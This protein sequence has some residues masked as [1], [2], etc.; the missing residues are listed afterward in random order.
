MFYE[1]EAPKPKAGQKEISAMVVLNASESRRLL[2]KATAALRK[3]QRVWKNGTIIIARGITDAYVTEELFHISVEPKA[4]QSVGLVVQGVPKAQW[5]SLWR[6]K[7]RAWRKH[8][9]W[10]SPPNWSL[11]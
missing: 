9:T 5:C 11:R 6:D 1:I 7:Q 2:A 3:V 4:G 8:S 10:S